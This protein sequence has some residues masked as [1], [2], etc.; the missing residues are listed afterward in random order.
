MKTSSPI[1]LSARQK[2]TSAVIIAAIPVGVQV[3]IASL[4]IFGK[5]EAFPFADEAIQH[6]A[7]WL[8]QVILVCI[9][10]GGNTIVDFNAAKNR[11]GIRHTRVNLMYFFFCIILMAVVVAILDKQLDWEWLGAVV[12]SGLLCVGLAYIVEVELAIA[13]EGLTL[14]SPPTANPGTEPT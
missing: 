2:F 1:V 3:A 10:V 9:A 11:N 4:L 13:A 12:V 8:M 6:P 7:F 5:P 14:T